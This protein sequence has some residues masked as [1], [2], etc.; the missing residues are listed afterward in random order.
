ML[1]LIFCEMTSVYSAAF[2][3]SLVGNSD[4]IKFIAVLFV[5]FLPTV[6]FLFVKRTEDCIGCFNKFTSRYSSF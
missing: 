2:S 3:K 4:D 1:V 6:C 5:T